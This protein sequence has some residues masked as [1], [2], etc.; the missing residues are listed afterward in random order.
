MALMKVGSVIR[1]PRR[2]F[3]GTSPEVENIVRGIIED[4]LTEYVNNIDFEIK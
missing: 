4:N 2:Q 3:L 1:I